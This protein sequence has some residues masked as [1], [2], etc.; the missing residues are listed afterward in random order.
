MLQQPVFPPL[1]GIRDYQPY[2]VPPSLGTG[3]PSHMDHF[4]T[5]IG[6]ASNFASK[7]Q[8]NSASDMFLHSDVPTWATS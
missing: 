5:W 1:L 6:Q 3:K 7:A 4:P 8:P 2:A